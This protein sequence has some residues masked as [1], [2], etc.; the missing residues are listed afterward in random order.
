MSS[1]L[2]QFR[3]EEVERL[4]AIQILDKLGLSLQTYLRMCILRLNKESGIP[5]SMKLEK[6]PNP[7]IAALQQASMIAEK[8]GIADM[9]LDE[10]NAEIAEARK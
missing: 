10:I 4:K 8:Y 1:V 5:F 6:E 9:T 3:T 7:G 2:I